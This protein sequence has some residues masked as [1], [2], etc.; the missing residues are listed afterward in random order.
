VP[1]ARKATS[2]LSI[3]GRFFL[4]AG[5]QHAIPARNKA[6]IIQRHDSG[7]VGN[8]CDKCPKGRGSV[9]SPTYRYG[10]FGIVFLDADHGPV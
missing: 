2:A 5:I 1:F 10:Q 6:E 4:A 7:K 8:V 9:P 3:S